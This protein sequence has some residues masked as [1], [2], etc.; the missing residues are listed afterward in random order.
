[1]A[2]ETKHHF[3]FKDFSIP[4]GVVGG[5]IL[6]VASIV[7]S[8]SNQITELKVFLA[9]NM[10]TQAELSEVEEKIIDIERNSAVLEYR[11]EQLESD[12]EDHSE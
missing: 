8:V 5:I 6:T 2:E 7:W 12:H 10:A 4:I 9:E 1:M 3:S 11:V